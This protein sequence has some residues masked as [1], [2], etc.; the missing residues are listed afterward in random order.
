M[1]L[2]LSQGGMTMANGMSTL[3]HIGMLRLLHLACTPCAT[4]TCLIDQT[5][6]Q[7][8]TCGPNTRTHV[9]HEVRETLGVGLSLN[10]SLSLVS[11][12]APNCLLY[13]S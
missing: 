7:F 3:P 5:A 13:G 4:G 6:G 2:S 1:V 11:R 10:L 9:M 12:L 8:C